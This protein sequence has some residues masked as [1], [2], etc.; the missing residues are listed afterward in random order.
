MEKT[1]YVI[2]KKCLLSL[3]AGF[4][5]F[6]MLM[7][8]AAVLAGTGR[9]GISGNPLSDKITKLV[10]GN[11]IPG[12][13]V[14]GNI[15]S[16]NLVSGNIVSG[17]IVS[18]N[19]VS[20]N[21]VSGNIVSGNIVS[22][23]LV[24]GNLVS[25]NLVSG[26]TVSGNKG[27]DKKNSNGQLTDSQKKRI[28]DNKTAYLKTFPDASPSDIKVSSD[29]AG[30]LSLTFTTSADAQFYEVT[31]YKRGGSDKDALKARYIDTDYVDEGNTSPKKME[32]ELT[33][34]SNSGYCI[35]ITSG[36][37]YVNDND[38]IEERM[39]HNSSAVLHAAPVPT[40]PSK[41]RIRDCYSTSRGVYLSTDITGLNDNKDNVYTSEVE[42]VTLK[43]KTVA[44]FTGKAQSADITSR[45]LKKNSFFML[46]A[47]GVYT[48]EEGNAHLGAWSDYTVFGTDF[49]DVSCKKLKKGISVSF[50]KYKGAY[51]YVIFVSGAKDSG[52][53]KCGKTSGT[54][55][56]IAG[57]YIKNLDGDCYVKV[58][59]LSKKTEAGK[60][61]KD[62][63]AVRV[64]I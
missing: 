49:T 50:S 58:R 2:I 18:G 4:L 8:P 48:D 12:N 10:S 54:S 39:C 22:G 19:I 29:A 35:Y 23:N 62:S 27:T 26:N 33:G 61:K 17:N 53:K 40:A 38:R 47:R 59:A 32:I 45:K 13:L 56:K 15:V 36:C 30:T 20:G 1:E 9:T 43:G 55:F 34:L 25:G 24:S 41:I 11:L 63:K 3:S 31:Y 44:A 16:G 64:R 21:I 28:V 42:I 46:R 60:G 6:V 37:Y 7:L 51:R 5:V 14:S 52:F 57:K